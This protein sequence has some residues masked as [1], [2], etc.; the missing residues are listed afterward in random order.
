MLDVVITKTSSCEELGEDGT[1]N[2]MLFQFITD[3]RN[4]DALIDCGALLAGI[5]N[6]NVAEY[7]SEN[8]LLKP[9]GNLKG[10]TFYD[11]STKEWMILE[12]SGRCLPKNQSS[13]KE[14]DTFALFDEP[15]CRGVDLKLHPDAIAALSL[16]Q[17]MCKYKFMQAAGRMRQLQNK[18]SLIIVGARRIFNEVRQKSARVDVEGILAWVIQ[19]TVQSIVRGIGVWS[20]QGIFFAT[21]RTPQHAVLDEKSDLQSYYGK[22]VQKSN[23]SKSA[24]LSRE[25]HFQRSGYYSNSDDRILHVDTIVERCEKYGNGYF[26]VRSGADEECERELNREIKEEEEEELEIE[27]V[28]T[29]NERD[30][31]WKQIFAEEGLNTLPTK[32]YQFVDALSIFWSDKKGLRRIKWSDNLFRTRNFIKTVEINGNVLDNYLRIPDCL[33]RFQSGQVLLLSDREGANICELFLERQASGI[34]CM[35]HML[36]HFC[37]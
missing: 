7:L 14:K 1:V 16:G 23:L 37:L 13:L 2:E 35:G 32:Q 24:A 26:V 17:G 21:E 28:S 30:W 31:D 6:R 11:E 4:I 5:S 33:V 20:D 22:P 3:N 29:R 9:K 8:L 25:D 18:Q 15:R 27:R 19:N 34:S 10:I 36:G 12:Q